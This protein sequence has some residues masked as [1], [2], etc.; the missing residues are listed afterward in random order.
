MLVNNITYFYCSKTKITTAPNAFLESWL[1]ED[2][3]H[4]LSISVL[5]EVEL[6]C[7]SYSL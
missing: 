5:L 4:L 7:L 1:I 6:C 3:V 2:S